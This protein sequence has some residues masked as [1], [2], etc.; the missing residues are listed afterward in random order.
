MKQILTANILLIVIL[1]ITI[2][3]VVWDIKF[4]KDVAD[5][6]Q[7]IAEDKEEKD[8]KKTNG[9]FG[10]RSIARQLAK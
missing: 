7:K 8:G 4:A 5:E 6:K 10:T 2:F 1:A 9:F 3:K